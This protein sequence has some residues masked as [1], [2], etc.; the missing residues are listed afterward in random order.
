[1]AQVRA[2][3]MGG[4]PAIHQDNSKKRERKAASSRLAAQGCC[5]EPASAL[6]PPVR[7]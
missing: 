5:I 1:M 3:K 2:A 4:D 7:A 6:E